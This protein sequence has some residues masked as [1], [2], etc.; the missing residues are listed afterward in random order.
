MNQC[1]DIIYQS[2]RNLSGKD[3]FVKRNLSG[4][5]SG[6][7]CPE[8]GH[9]WKKPAKNGLFLE[10]SGKCYTHPYGVSILNFKRR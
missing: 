9:D 7:Y 6:R 5:V 2:K 3:N 10:V 4:Q 8:T 1:G